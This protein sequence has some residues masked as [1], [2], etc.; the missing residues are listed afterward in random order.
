MP[1]NPVSH[2]ATIPAVSF[3]TDGIYLSIE[4]GAGK[5]RWPLG[6]AERAILS[7]V[8]SA[9]T[10]PGDLTVNVIDGH[11]LEMLLGGKRFTAGLGQ[12]ERDI[13]SFLIGT[14][15]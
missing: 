15:V 8:Q 12:P 6:T 7:F 1:I 11:T 5:Y 10:S 14:P 9:G 4:A 13:A 2:T 3:S